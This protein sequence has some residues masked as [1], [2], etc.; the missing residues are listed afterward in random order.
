MAT[1][2]DGQRLFDE[3]SMEIRTDSFRRDSMERTVPGLD[4]VLSIDLGRR[5]R[6]ITQTGT[7]RAESRL[8]MD[9]KIST[10]SAHM[11]GNT[12][13]LV[14]GN[15]KFDN[16]RMDSFKILSEHMDG[17]GISVEYEIVYTQLV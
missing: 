15:M 9:S 7:L 1:T 17:V 5:N 8:Q 6:Q 14:T 2:L 10:I 4:G 3:Q 12:Y 13:T 11:D 16:L